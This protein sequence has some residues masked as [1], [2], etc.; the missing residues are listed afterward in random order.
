M[1]CRLCRNL[2]LLLALS[3]L[4]SLQGVLSAR[5]TGHAVFGARV[6]KLSCTLGED[7]LFLIHYCIPG[8][9]IFVFKPKKC[10]HLSVLIKVYI[11]RMYFSSSI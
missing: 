8:S 1:H 11:L 10:M 2:L 7:A 6:F 9:W 3:T 4:L 5:A